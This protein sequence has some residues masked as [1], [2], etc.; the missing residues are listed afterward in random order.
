MEKTFPILI[1]E[2]DLVSRKTLEKV[3]TRDGYEVVTAVN[4]K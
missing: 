4:G 2:E 1:A 3:L